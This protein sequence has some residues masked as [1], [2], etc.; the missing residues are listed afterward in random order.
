MQTARRPVFGVHALV[1]ICQH[2]GMSIVTRT[3]SHTNTPVGCHPF[4]PT[5]LIAEFPPEPVV[6]MIVHEH[7]V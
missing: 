6:E 4:T 7:V 1:R 5:V 2:D 3:G